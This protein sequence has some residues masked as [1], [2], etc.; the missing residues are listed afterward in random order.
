MNEEMTNEQ[1]EEAFAELKTSTEFGELLERIE[2]SK[3]RVEYF[4]NVYQAELE[5]IPKRLK[6][7]RFG[8]HMNMVI[9]L[10]IMCFE[11]FFVI[12]TIAD[13]GMAQ[14]IG[15]FAMLFIFILFLLQL[16]RTIKSFII[17]NMNASQNFM[18]MYVMT[19]DIHNMIEERQYCNRILMRMR[20]Y[21]ED[22]AL[23]D[24]KISAKEIDVDAALSS[25]DKMDFDIEPFRYTEAFRR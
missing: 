21:N 24:A 14:F 7:Q 6:S 11:A 13:D 10:L 22:I 25:L 18:T 5:G 19:H 12:Y 17:Y 1:R 8:M 23:I 15:L 2:Q 16:W 9:V 3:E 4:T 20:D